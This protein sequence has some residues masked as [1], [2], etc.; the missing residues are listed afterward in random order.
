MADVAELG[1]SL[2][3]IQAATDYST[4]E[5]DSLEAEID[6]IRDAVNELLNKLL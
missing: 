4:D 6:E 1:S 3:A 2:E 5:T